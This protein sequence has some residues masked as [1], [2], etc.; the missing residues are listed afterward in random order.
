MISSSGDDRRLHVR[1]PDVALALQLFDRFQGRHKR[2]EAGAVHEVHVSHV[3]DQAATCR[4]Q[5]GPAA[6]S[7]TRPPPRG[8]ARA[9]RPDHRGAVAFRDVNLHKDMLETNVSITHRRRSRL[10]AHD[11]HPGC[12]SALQAARGPRSGKQAG[13]VLL[14]IPSY[15]P[16]RLKDRLPAPV[17]QRGGQN[18]GSGIQVQRAGRARR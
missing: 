17:D 18:H 1:E 3:D 5:S 13:T 15:T 2:A 11:L 6:P 9:Q 7:E 14:S 12:A 10:L 16:G 8:D 4:R